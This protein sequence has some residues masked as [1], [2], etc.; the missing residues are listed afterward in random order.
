M[1]D[2]LKLHRK[3]QN[4]AMYK[5]LNSKQRDILIQC[6]ILANYEES[7]WEYNNESYKCKPGQFISSLDS[8][9]KNCAKD[10]SIQNI[11]TC[12]L[13][14]EKWHFLTNES[15]NKNRLI[16]IV[17]WEQYQ[18]KEEKLT[19]KITCDQ[20]ATNK[21]LTT[22]KNL[23]I[24]ELKED[25]IIMPEKIQASQNS[26][27]LINKKLKKKEEKIE[28]L[29]E[30][31]ETS[32]KFYYDDFVQIYNTKRGT[33]FTTASQFGRS[34]FIQLVGQGF[35]K[36]DFIL[37]LEN[38]CKDK[39]AI[40]K[41]LITPDKLCQQERFELYRNIQSLAKQK[42]ERITVPRNPDIFIPPKKDKP[43]PTAEQEML[44]IL[45]KGAGVK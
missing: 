41:G 39:F 3:I 12:L 22:I 32:T 45:K 19:S 10:V 30:T 37:V 33:K 13:K 5:A 9:K 11:R 8:I 25:I 34:R 26:N 15:T 43:E 27:I 28:G 16:T 2:W 21:Q 17:K 42:E 44:E 1:S 35:T 36:D 20:Q 24:K 40:E 6:L 29:E 31:F 14:L 18:K 23:I 4:S 38:A 7:E